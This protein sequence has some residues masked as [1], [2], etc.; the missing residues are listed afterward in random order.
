MWDQTDFE[1]L[2]EEYR[3]H[4]RDFKES[5]SNALTGR[6]FF[7]TTHG[8][9][10]FHA[11]LE[12]RGGK[13]VNER[14]MMQILLLERGLQELLSLYWLVENYA[15][16]ACQGRLRFL[17]ETYTLVKE[18]NS[19]KKKAQSDFINIIEMTVDGDDFAND[20]APLRDYLSGKRRQVRGELAEENSVHSDVYDLMSNIGSHPHSIQSM[21]LDGTYDENTE[22]DC[23]EFGLVFV[24]ALAAQYRRTFEETPLRKWV[25]RELDGIMLQ[26]QLQL[27]GLPIFLKEDMDYT[28]Q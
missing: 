4:S 26:A 19:N 27:D 6:T 22:K 13:H 9:R 10:Q 24:Y 11:D 5:G 14:H 18:I 28:P 1:S 20:S 15:Y 2:R 21:K 25:E 7:I 12:E 3:E 17:L 23:L 16:T 8:L